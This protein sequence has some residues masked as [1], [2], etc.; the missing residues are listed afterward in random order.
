MEPVRIFDGRYR[1]RSKP[2]GPDRSVEPVGSIF[3]GPGLDWLKFLDL[4]PDPD[5]IYWIF[6]DPDPNVDYTIDIIMEY[7]LCFAHL[8]CWQSY[9]TLF[10]GNVGDNFD[11]YQ[12]MIEF[13]F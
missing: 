4:E 8:Y 2:V 9:S 6:S 1:Y 13:Y 5:P 3:F 12:V 10:L 11:N 7:F